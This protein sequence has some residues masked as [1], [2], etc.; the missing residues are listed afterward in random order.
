M[1]RKKLAFTL[2]ELLVVLAIIL[3]LASLLFPVFRMA[4]ASA[5][6]IA[7][8]SNFRQV[9]LATSLYVTDWDDRMM[10]VNHQPAA[11]PNSTNDRTWV[12]LTLPYA[13]SFSIFTCPSDSG[14]RPS[15]ETTFDQDLVPGDIYS[16]YYTASRRVNT[17]YNFMYLAP[18][19]QAP[20]G[21]YISEPRPMSMVSEPSQTLL[22]VDSLWSRRADGTPYGG[23]SWLVVPPCRFAMQNGVKTDTFSLHGARAYAPNFGWADDKD[24]P[25]VYGAAWPWH[26]GR[27]N[28]IRLDGSVRSIPA[29]E[30]SA[31]C[32]VRERW[33][34]VIQDRINYIWDLN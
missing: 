14:E 2:P 6:R 3:V 15:A 32:E 17:G 31:G 21:E 8:V 34:G 24:S 33:E 4:R 26:E 10:P 18:V 22:F 25:Y 20:N 23:G 11:A 12:Q 28:M 27:V 29:D 1:A 5:H 30:L 19:Y 7:C 13:R 9:H 16:K